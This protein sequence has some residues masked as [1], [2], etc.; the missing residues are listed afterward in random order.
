ML[1]GH[2][3]QWSKDSHCESAQDFH[4]GAPLAPG[5]IAPVVVEPGQPPPDFAFGYAVA[6]QLSYET[7]QPDSVRRVCQSTAPGL[8]QK[9]NRR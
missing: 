8:C 6:S 5:M 4:G 7:G 9:Q 3:A 2:D 1:P